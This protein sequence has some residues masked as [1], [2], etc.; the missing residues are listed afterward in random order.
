LTFAHHTQAVMQSSFKSNPPS[1]IEEIR[2]NL[3]A[4]TMQANHIILMGYSLPQDDITY[5]AFF[6]ASCQRHKGPSG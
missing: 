4:T 1:F 3:R 6:S 5:C 2:R